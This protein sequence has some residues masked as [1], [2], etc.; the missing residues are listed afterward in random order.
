MLMGTN[1]L[2]LLLYIAKKAHK[3]TLQKLN[4][5]ITHLYMRTLRS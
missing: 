1:Q 5:T 3:P 2:F 4:A